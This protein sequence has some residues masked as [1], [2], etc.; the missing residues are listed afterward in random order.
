MAAI[1]KGGERN[2]S[3]DLKH[4]CPALSSAELEAAKE[5]LRQYVALAWRVF[6]RLE[7]D[8]EAMAR[9]E[10]L[11]AS[12]RELSMNHKRPPTNTSSEK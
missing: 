8:P 9:Y 6:E 11:T 4:L 1:E 3:L 7:K 5:T 12:R 10:A 2:S